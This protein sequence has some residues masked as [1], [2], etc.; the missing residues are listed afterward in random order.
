MVVEVS[1]PDVEERAM[2]TSAAASPNAE[3]VA[4][5]RLKAWVREIATLTRAHAVY[6]CDGSAEEY[7]RL[8][9][10]LV[11]AGTFKRLSDAKR[12]NSYLARSDPSDVARVEDRTFIC[13]AREDDAGPT[14]NWHEPGKMRNTLSALFDGSMQGRTMYVV[15]FSMGPL[16]SDKSYIGVQLTDSAYVAVSMRIMTRMGQ[17]ALDAL[18]ANGDF[19]PCVH[20]VGM[21]LGDAHTTSRG[22]VTLS[23]STSSTSPRRA[24]SGPTGRGTAA[25]RCSARSAWRCGS[26]R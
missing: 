6:W 21:P 3:R 9:Q 25:T 19:V 14:N 11:D 24:R 16:G 4:H 22:R 15:P 23:A 8:C 13:S 17:A 7:N 20:S 10:G 1:I 18:G 12:P 5:E 2:S 26:R